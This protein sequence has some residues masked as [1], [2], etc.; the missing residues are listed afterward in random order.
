MG[1]VA[2]FTFLAVLADGL[3]GLAGG[4]FSERWLRRH[5]PGLVG[6]AAGTLLTASFL[7]VLPEAVEARGPAAFSWAFASFVTLALLEGWLG[8][9]HHHPHGQG[10]TARSPTLPA[11]LLG[12]DALHNLGDGAAVAAAFLVSPQAGVATSLAVIAHELPQEV[13]DYAL[14][15]AS[16]WT[17]GRS[18]L[19]LAGVQLTAMVGAA[20]MLL[21]SRLLPSLQGVVLAVAAGTFLY[22]GAVD[23]LPELRHGTAT[24][25]RQRVVGLMLGLALLLALH[26][27]EAR[28]AMGG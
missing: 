6:F 28:L 22:I 15:R 10:D 12:S 14:L 11:A 3:A 24:E 21:G 16:G 7:D 8:H 27:V 18:L 19:T 1:H 25:L 2:L 26:L 23:L 9:P 5:L 13:G 4:L 17:R 20:G